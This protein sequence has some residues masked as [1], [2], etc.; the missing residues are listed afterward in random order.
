MRDGKAKIRNKEIKEIVFEAY[1]NNDLY[2]L[3]VEIDRDAPI[4]AIKEINTIN[5]NN[6]N[7][8]HQRFCHVNNSNIQKLADR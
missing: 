3:K 5:I 1:R 7:L 8:W 2:V 4:N 6:E